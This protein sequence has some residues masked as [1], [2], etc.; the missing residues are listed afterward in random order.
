MQYCATNQAILSGPLARPIEGNPVLEIREKLGFTQTDLAILAA[1]SLETRD[2]ILAVLKGIEAGAFEKLTSLG[3][4]H[5]KK[6]FERAR[7]NVR[8]LERC[9]IQWGKELDESIADEVEFLV[10]K[11]RAEQGPK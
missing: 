2:S 3:W 5:L 9:Y 1:P 10:G 11:G 6:V 8:D 7:F 4:S